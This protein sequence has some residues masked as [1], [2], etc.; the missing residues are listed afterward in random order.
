MRFIHGVMY[1]AAVTPLAGKGGHIKYPGGCP[2]AKGACSCHRL[3]L[4]RHGAAC[5]R[6]SMCAHARLSS[7]YK[8]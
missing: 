7:T 5:A 8:Q 2:Q 1:D 6:G 3:V 4:A